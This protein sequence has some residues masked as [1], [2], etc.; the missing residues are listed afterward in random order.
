MA[1]KKPVSGS[2]GGASKKAAPSGSMSNAAKPTRATKV[3]AARQSIREGWGD[4]AGYQSP[5]VPTEPKGPWQGYP[6][7]TPPP[8][9]PPTT[10][11]DPEDAS[12]T[13]DTAARLELERYMS[14]T[15]FPLDMVDFF[16]DKINK[17]ELPED[18]TAED[19]TMV[20]V[21]HPSF[22]ARFPVI[23][24][25]FNKRKAGDVSMQ[26][27]TPAA[28][29]EYERS[30]KNTADDFGLSGWVSDPQQISKL[31]LNGVDVDEA[32]ERI[33]LAGYAA[34]QAPPAFREAFLS[35]HNLTEGNLVGYFLDPNKEEA[36]IRKQ[37]SLGNIMGAAISN[38]FGNRW[39]IAERIYNRGYVPAGEIT[40]MSGVMSEF[41]RA[42]M[43]SALS[44]GLGGTVD[45]TAR[46]DA[47]F[48]DSA[49]TT[50]VAKVA[51]ERT[52]RFNRSGGAVEGRTGITGL[53]T[54]STT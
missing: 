19:Y 51:A 26:I 8:Q 16:L 21:E 40:G 42:A 44:S 48:G 35:R 24:E 36:E 49:A 18:A 34:M 53:G 15:G 11:D 7:T 46:I 4:G 32:K 22:Q 20:A 31:I 23:V 5:A 38:G 47:A 9:P 13:G 25:Q 52:G 33:N 30:L 37:V 28:V 29:L 41:A 3:K 39:E 6:G 2:V 27:M 1:K 43:T 12:P 54:A 17:G 50:E 10:P 14:L 45:E